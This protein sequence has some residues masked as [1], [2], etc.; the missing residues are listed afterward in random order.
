M[1][2]QTARRRVRAPHSSPQ[3]T[4]VLAGRDKARRQPMQAL[5]CTQHT[6]PAI[7][8][9]YNI[10]VRHGIP[11]PPRYPAR[12]G[13]PERWHC[14]LSRGFS[15]PFPQAHLGPHFLLHCSAAVPKRS[16]L[17]VGAAVSR[18]CDYLSQGGTSCR[19][20]TAARPHFFP[21]KSA[22]R[23]CAHMSSPTRPYIRVHA[24]VRTFECR[25][26]A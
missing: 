20:R 6:T 11:A 4:C 26:A 25:A 19:S 18:L 5:W 7:P 3:V 21:I 13:I 8:A 15:L 16:L 17:T 1:A 9:R 2:L 24:H 14:Q 22:S 10:P 12:H 23:R